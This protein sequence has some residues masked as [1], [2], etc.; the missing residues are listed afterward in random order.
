MYASCYK[1]LL[2]SIVDKLYSFWQNLLNLSSTEIHDGS[3]GRESKY[4]IHATT[5]GRT[6]RRSGVTELIAD[7]LKHFV[8]T[9]S[10]NEHFIERNSVN[11]NILQLCLTFSILRQFIS[12]WFNSSLSSIEA[13]LGKKFFIYIF[14]LSNAFPKKNYLRTYVVVSKSFRPDI[15]KPRQMENAVR[16]ISAI[17]ELL[18]HRCEKCVEI[19]GD[20]VEK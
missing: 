10:N 20:Y 2:C 19:R 1:L 16:D 8:K 7:F 6:D 5:K 3:S 14:F 11:W 18:V 13:L 17:Y 15:Q 12:R 9:P 4:S